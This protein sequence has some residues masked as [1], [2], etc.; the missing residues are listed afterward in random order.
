MK[1]SILALCFFSV[2]LLGLKGQTAGDIVFTSVPVISGKVIFEQ[3]IPVDQGLS[4]EQMYALLYKWGKDNYAGN[5][6]L[7]GIRF[8]DRS[9]NITVSS[10]VE[11]LLPANRAGVQEK[12]LMNYRFDA[13]ITAAGCILTV[14]DIT[15]QDKDSRGSL[16][17]PKLTAAEE[18]ITDQAINAGGDAGELRNNIRKGT[19]SFLNDLYAD[20]NN[21][22]KLSK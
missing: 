10:K 22:F 1:K 2:Y 16:F 15:Y 17:F 9:Q 11:L 19:L 4:A 21:L 20:L 3:F 7:S 5:P 8:D 6:L 12:V 14:R 18:V 13:T